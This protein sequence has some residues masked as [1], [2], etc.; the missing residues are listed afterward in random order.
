MAEALLLNSNFCQIYFESSFVLFFQ[1]N[2][3]TEILREKK[4]YFTQ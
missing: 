4:K 2:L 1:E 3:F